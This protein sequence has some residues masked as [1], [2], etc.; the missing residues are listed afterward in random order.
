MLISF[1]QFE[2][3][4]SHALVGVIYEQAKK[5]IEFVTANREMRI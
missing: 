2:I 3:V 4:N 1:P 5:V